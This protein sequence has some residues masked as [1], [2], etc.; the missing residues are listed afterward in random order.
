MSILNISRRQVSFLR[1]GFQQ[2]SHSWLSRTISA[3]CKRTAK[4]GC[5]TKQTDS[6]PMTEQ[7]SSIGY[8]SRHLVIRF[9]RTSAYKREQNVGGILKGPATRSVA[10][11]SEAFSVL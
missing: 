1:S 2:D 6:I 10:S 11:Q 4:H 5:P 8:C 3:G 9:R 7:I